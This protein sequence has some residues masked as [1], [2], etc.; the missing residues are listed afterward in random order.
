[1]PWSGKRLIMHILK[2][3]GEIMKR[4]KTG[5]AP[6]ALLGRSGKT[7]SLL[8]RGF[9]A[10]GRIEGQKVGRLAAVARGCGGP[11]KLRRAGGERKIAVE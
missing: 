9:G 8:R 6:G 2:S 3:I 11:R 10:R 4:V 7:D 1:M 5:D